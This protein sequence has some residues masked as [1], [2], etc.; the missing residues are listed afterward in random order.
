MPCGCKRRHSKKRSLTLNRGEDVRK[1]KP[2]TIIDSPV[3]GSQYRVGGLL[4]QGGFGSA[5]RVQRLDTKQRPIE[6][7][8]LKVTRDP[9]SWHREAY[10]GEILKP[11]SRAIRMYESF[12]LLPAK[13][14]QEVLYCLV[15]ELAEGGTIQDYLEQTR[16]PWSAKR[17]TQEIVALLKLLDRLHGVGALHRDITPTNIFVC[18]NRLLKLGDFGI[19]KLVLAG[20][21]ATASV[22]NPWFVSN[23][24]A[25]GAQ[26]YWMASDDV[27]QMG[28]LLAMLLQGDANNL[29]QEQQ[30]EQLAC[31]DELRGIIV[32]AIG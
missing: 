7:L 5:Y 16:R 21:Q 30:V 6:A 12:P 29:I 3:T 22:F 23:R 17:A 9:E 28:Q 26:R 2:E 4:G 20:Q 13:K 11:C 24:M 25:R 10:F 14:G 31:N 15:F 1:L 8:C 27:Y 18:R 19:A 32:K